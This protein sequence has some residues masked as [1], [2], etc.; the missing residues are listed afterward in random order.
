M[1]DQVVEK[2]EL[3]IDALRYANDHN[4]DISNR[5]NVV[6]ILKVLDPD[7]KQ[8]VDEFMELLL[9]GEAFMDKTARDKEPKKTDL[10]N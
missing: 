6:K 3:V 5:D 4:L 2:S 9:S 1:N 8:D 10:P 7:H